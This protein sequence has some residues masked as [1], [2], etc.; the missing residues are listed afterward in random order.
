M[1]KRI[2]KFVFDC[3]KSVFTQDFMGLSAEMAFYTIFSF[4]PFLIFMVSLFKLFGSEQLINSIIAYFAP[5]IPSYVHSY[6]A[7]R[8]TVI[9]ASDYSGFMTLTFFVA[10]FIASNAIFALIKGLNRAYH[11]EETRPIWFTRLLSLAFLFLITFVIFLGTYAVVFGK[12]ILGYIASIKI[13]P[14]FTIAMISVFRWP[15]I[16]FALYSVFFTNYYIMPNIKGFKRAKF[17]A[18]IPG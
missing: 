13:L 5:I 2:Y 9:I 14:D 18:A 3:A 17:F 10:M 4:F 7:S 16:F 11:V 8:L 6:I 1:F 12:I 15:I